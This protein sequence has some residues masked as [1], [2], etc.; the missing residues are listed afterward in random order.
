MVDNVLDETDHI[1][2]MT[3]PTLNED[4]NLFFTRNGFDQDT[5]NECDKYARSRF[6]NTTM[7]ASQSQGYCSYTLA[8]SDGYILQFRPEAF[9]LDMDV[10]GDAKVIYGHLAPATTYMGI[11]QGIARKDASNESPILHAYLQETMP[12]I[13]LSQ[14][15]KNRVESADDA[16]E[17]R[18]RLMEDLAQAFALGFHNR[19]YPS[20]GAKVIKGKVGNSIRWRLDRLKALPGYLYTHVS[21]VY[22]QLKS[23]ERSPWC[24]T[25]GDLLPCNMMVDPETGHLTGLIDWAEA[26]WLPFGM[27]LYGI[28]EVLGCDVP[29]GG[30]QYYDDHEELRRHFWHRFLISSCHRDFG[31][32]PWLEE[33]QVSRKLGIL[34]WKGIAFDDG[35]LDRVVEV[36]RDDAEMQRLEL[37]L[38]TSNLVGDFWTS[39]TCGRWLQRFPVAIS[40][41]WGRARSRMNMSGGSFEESKGRRES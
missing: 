23:V 18:R 10:C 41:F 39:L 26:E 28:E 16:R 38:E 36:G 29:L 32:R 24:L 37:F 15:M 40:R 12:G 8:L 20:R 27:A 30:F 35:R 11:V 6:P 22:R 7:T 1:V 33:I 3:L 19:R 21:E 9:K 13:P 31:A 4:I 25:H 5:R 17:R 34:L 14:F 2:D